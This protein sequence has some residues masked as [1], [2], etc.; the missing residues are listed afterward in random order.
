MNSPMF[1]ANSSSRGSFATLSPDGS[2]FYWRWRGRLERRPCQIIHDLWIMLRWSPSHL[3]VAD[4]LRKD[5]P[6]PLF[7]PLCVHIHKNRRKFNIVSSHKKSNYLHP[8]FCLWKAQKFLTPPKVISLRRTFRAIA[9]VKGLFHYREINDGQID[10]ILKSLLY[11]CFFVTVNVPH[12]ASGLQECQVKRGQT[13]T[14]TVM[15]KNGTSMDR[16][17][18]FSLLFLRLFAFLVQGTL[19]P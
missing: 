2:P 12:E 8:H 3:L 17:L 4:S 13:K 10:I 16:I 11:P 18:K 15:Q 19:I 14:A 1:R 7:W 5:I 9:K 6:F